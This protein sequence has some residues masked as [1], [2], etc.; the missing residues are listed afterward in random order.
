[1]MIAMYMAKSTPKGKRSFMKPPSA[2]GKISSF[3]FSGIRDA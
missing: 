1:M 3:F 2:L